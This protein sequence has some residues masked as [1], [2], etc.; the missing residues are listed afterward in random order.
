MGRGRS[1]L[2]LF[3]VLVALGAYI[4]FVERKREPATEGEGQAKKK[5]FSVEAAKIEE[6]QVKASS[7]DQTTLEKEGERWKLVAPVAADADEGEVSG[8]TSNI[9]S[10]EQQRVVEDKAADLKPYGLDTPRIAI[11]FRVAGDK[12]MKHLLLGSKTPTGGDMYAK[13]DDTAQVFLV[14]GYLDN[15]F[16]RSTFDLRDKAVLKIERD[17]IDGIDLESASGSI[18]FAKNQD[19][20]KI[21]APVQ[22]RA[23]YGAV[24]GLL[25][26]VATARMKAI[27][28]P[29]AT[30]LKK[31]GLDKPDYTLGLS[32]GSARSTFL[33]G[34]K[35]PDGQFYAKDASRPMVF[36][37]DSVLVD[38][39]K[40]PAGDYRMKDLFEFRTFT[41]SRLEFTRD[42]TT[43]V[44]EKQ[45]G[46]DKDA[47]EKWV[48]V[49]PKKDIEEGKILDFLSRLTNLRADSFV[50]AL[51]A[52]AGQAAAVKAISSEGKKEDAVTFFKAGDNVYATR[53][54]EPGAAKV[55]PTEFNEAIKLLDGLK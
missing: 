15:T 34:A 10:L 3:L 13:L 44:F 14:S 17:K 19:A 7:G 54:G 40:K 49:Q 55:T 45:K 2:V 6:L 46:K 9:A 1:T 35:T 22:A 50:D 26:R 23:D 33:V 51:P 43:L 29:E 52:G 53:P 32:A 39:L 28:D 24:E 8:I 16:D 30:D 11:G 27:V 4:F 37:V 42:G 21:D 47:P 48:Q 36:T 25:G 12:A 20:W 18:R 41:G 5:V 38:D 31:Y